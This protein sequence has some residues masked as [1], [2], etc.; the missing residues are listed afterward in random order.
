MVFFIVHT[1]R[2]T[3]KGLD[4]S[5]LNVC[6]CLFLCFMLVLV[7]LVLGFDMLDA[8]RGPDLVWL[9][10]TPMRPCLDV[11]IWEASPDA[12]LLSTYH[13]LPAPCDD[14]LIMFVHATRWLSMHLYMLAYMSMHKSCLLVCCPFFNTMMLWTFDPKL[15]LSL[16]DTTFCLLVCLL[17]C[18]LPFLFLFLPCLSC[19]SALCLFSYDLC[20]FSFYCLSV[21]FFCLSLHVHTW[22]ED[23]WS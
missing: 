13:S 3:S 14:M 5:Y 15:H 21:G 16:A 20:F 10:L 22:S 19:L 6:A 9:H 11:T 17:A 1:P 23:A 18:L 8:L 7:S 4:H 12:G 2:P